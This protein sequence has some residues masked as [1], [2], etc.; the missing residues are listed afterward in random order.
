[1]GNWT[2]LI[3]GQ[4]CHHNSREDIDADL[5]TKKF[6]ELLKA[7]GH[8]IEQADFIVHGRRDSLL[9]IEKKPEEK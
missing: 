9:P 5:A 3:N 8:S 2:I 7:Q 1:M 6:I 4:G